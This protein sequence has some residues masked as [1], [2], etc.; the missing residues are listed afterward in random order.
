M[1]YAEALSAGV[2]RFGVLS[3]GGMRLL[4]V[5]APLA[6]SGRGVPSHMLN[7][8]GETDGSLLYYMSC[9]DCDADR[10][11]SDAATKEFHR[12]HAAGLIGGCRRICRLLVVADDF[13]FDLASC[14][15]ARAVEK[16]ATFVDVA[17]ETE[18]TRRT[19]A[20]LRQI[21][22]NM[23][24]D[25]QR[26]PF[27]PGPITGSQD[28]VPIEDYSDEEF[29]VLL[30]DGKTLPRDIHTI[31]LVQRALATLDDR[32]RAV[33][34]QTVLQRQRSPGRS[35]MY[36]GSAEALAGRW[37]TTTV[38][39]RRIRRAGLRAITKFIRENSK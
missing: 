29:A 26:N 5:D 34:A 9:R 20:W 35:Y 15:L 6:Q 10:E 19:L 14:T 37:G 36:R 1:Q 32:T 16:A 25:S 23:L 7:M 12:R 18:Q 31:G 4:G 3:V 38:N 2:Y 30:C 28:R 24:V 39:I 17:D 21:A 8:Q 13:A 22:R 27:R 11:I 33:L